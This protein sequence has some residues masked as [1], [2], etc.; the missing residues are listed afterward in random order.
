M[1]RPPKRTAMYFRLRSPSLIVFAGTALLIAVSCGG[2]STPASPTASCTFTIS[3]TVV[4]VGATSGATALTVATGST[5]AWNVVSSA[6]FL[7]VTSGTGQTG[8]GTVTF[9]VAE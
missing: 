7:T 6:A 2:G 5:C 8:P 4:S 9:T 3:S 1:A